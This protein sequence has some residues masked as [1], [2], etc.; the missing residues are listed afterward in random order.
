MS[1]KRIKAIEYIRGIAMLGVIGIHTGAYS[2]SNPYVN[3]HLFVLLEILTRFSVPIFFFVSAFGLF[4]SYDIYKPINYWNYYKRR[5]QSVLIPYLVWSL[6]YM[7]HYSWISADYN[8]WKKPLIYKYFLFGLSS[9]QLYFLIILMWFYLFMPVWRSV[10]KQITEKPVMQL[11]VLLCLQILINYYSSYILSPSFYDAYINIAVEYRFSYWIIHYIF[12]FIFGAFCA[13][14]YQKF[15]DFTHKHKLSITCFFLSTI[16]GMMKYYYNLLASGYTPEEAVN[17]VHQLS[18]IGVLYTF[19]AALFLTM[20]FSLKQNSNLLTK[21]L[22]YLAEHSYAIYLVHPLVMYYLSSYL[23]EIGKIM[24]GTITIGFY[25]FTVTIS[26]ILS[27]I[28]KTI[29]KY[30]PITGI[31][32]LGLSPKR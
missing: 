16:I 19:A 10:I 18:P 22:D 23:S 8:I 27:I 4:K 29:G 24:T 7:L 14:K 30:L 13:V 5:I 21:F 26:L 2:L 25:I 15:I 31:L 12:I 3:K 20:L 1:T 6:L 28:I 17:T 9:Y 32:L 11:S